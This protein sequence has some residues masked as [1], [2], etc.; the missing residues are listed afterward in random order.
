MKIKESYIELKDLRF[1]AYH[2]VLQK[3]QQQGNSYLLTL[4]IYF[5]ATLA[6]E[7]D[8]V[9]NTI[10]YA[11]VYE[12]IKEVMAQ[13]SQLLEHVVYRIL[14]ALP[15]HFPSLTSATC[16]IVKVTPPIATF[17]GNGASFTATAE[18]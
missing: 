10:N 18:Y 7:N 13:P 4:R 9:K 1:F 15:S 6:M 8:S 2:G 3:E 12:V 16:T 11:E 5:P 17:I 14:K